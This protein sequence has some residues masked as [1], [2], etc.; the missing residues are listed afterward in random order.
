MAEADSACTSFAAQPQHNIFADA[1]WSGT[2]P[3]TLLI[4]QHDPS[5]RSCAPALGHSLGVT[6]ICIIA[7]AL[8]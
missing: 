1:S 7:F 6:P 2:S 3:L 5:Q 8:K 4:L